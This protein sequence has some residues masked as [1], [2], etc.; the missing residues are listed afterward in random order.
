MEL[1]PPLICYVVEVRKRDS[2]RERES[3]CVYSLGIISYAI[4]CH[5]ARFL[6]FSN[7]IDSS[8]PILYLSLTLSLTLYLSLSHT[9]PNPYPNNV[10]LNWLHLIL[11]SPYLTVVFESNYSIHYDPDSGCQKSQFH[12]LLLTTRSWSSDYVFY[13]FMRV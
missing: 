10:S 4:L 5:V 12:F 13:H 7:L 3:V 6:C 2:E 11:F 8:V 1:I 9:H